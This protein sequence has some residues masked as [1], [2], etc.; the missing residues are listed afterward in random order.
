MKLL[1]VF[2]SGFF[3]NCLGVVY[4]IFKHSF[5]TVPTRILSFGVPWSL[6]EFWQGFPGVLVIV[7]FIYL[8][9]YP[10]YIFLGLSVFLSAWLYEPARHKP[11]YRAKP[12][13]LALN[14]FLSRKT[15]KLRFLA[16]KKYGLT[17]NAA[18]T[19]LPAFFPKISMLVSRSSKSN[20]NFVDF[21]KISSKLVPNIW[22]S[23]GGFK[24]KHLFSFF[25]GFTRFWTIN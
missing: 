25:A 9:N 19:G 8:S 5:F 10:I 3:L 15:K 13:S 2:F 1:W 22:F 14:R 17:R 4:K 6:N 20:R 18:E 21:E 23:V 11:F 12:L 24:S 16:K 7:N